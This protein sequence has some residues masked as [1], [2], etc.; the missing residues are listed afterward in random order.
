VAKDRKAEP[1]RMLRLARSML[2]AIENKTAEDLIDR[3]YQNQLSLL[4]WKLTISAMQPP[5][6][7]IEFKISKSWRR[8]EVDTTFIVEQRSVPSDKS[9]VNV[10]SG[11]YRS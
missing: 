3:N 7:Q 11:H 6:A 9:E 8:G 4:Y 1:V 10:I 2:L 5:I